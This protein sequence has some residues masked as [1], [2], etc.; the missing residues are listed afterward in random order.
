MPRRGENIYK[1]KDGRWEGRYIRSYTVDGK[2]KYG[3]VYGKTYAETKEKLAVYRVNHQKAKRPNCKLTVSELMILWLQDRFCRVKQSSY[4]CYSN[5]VERHISPDLGSLYVQELNAEKL[6]TYLNQKKEKGRADGKGGLASKTVSDIL[7]VLK[8]ALKLAQK[9]HDFVDTECVLDVKAPAVGRQRIET[10]GQKETQRMSSLLLE[11]WNMKNASVILVMNTGIRLGELCGLRWSDLDIQENEL[12]ISRTVQ[13]I[14]VGKKTALVVQTPKSESSE[15]I[16]PIQPKLMEL[17]ASLR[18]STSEGCYMLSGKEIP[19]DPRTVQYRF[20][21]FLWNNHFAIHNF[22]VLRH[23]FASRC[24][25]KGMDAKCL[26][27]L[28]GHSNIKTTL[29]LYVHPSM[30]QKR[31]YLEKVSTLV[32]HA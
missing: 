10:L 1:R 29:Q 30:E 14:R 3:S 2:A 31:A 16:I 9:K 5:L 11:N 32:C 21:K 12:R 20:R 22:H 24:I 4:V 7:F 23:S 27:E 25:E 18:G 6:E 19:I 8:S 15:R 26:S 13:R 28:L 17:L